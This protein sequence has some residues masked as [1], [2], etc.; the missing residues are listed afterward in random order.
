MTGFP[1]PRLP[2]PAH[3][4]PHPS[5]FQSGQ[6]RRIFQR[7]LSDKLT[8]PRPAWPLSPLPC[9]SFQLSSLHVTAMSTLQL[10]LWSVEHS[11]FN[12]GELF[13]RGG[14]EGG[15][16]LGIMWRGLRAN[17]FCLQTMNIQTARMRVVTGSLSPEVSWDRRRGFSCCHLGSPFPF[18]LSRS[19]W[20][21]VGFS[22]T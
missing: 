3:S 21:N 10:I 4:H 19:V 17:P 9:P 7:A 13:L 15:K 18:L 11:F 2:P 16:H 22:L 5:S 20:T 8:K 1:V 14:K 6:G 12:L